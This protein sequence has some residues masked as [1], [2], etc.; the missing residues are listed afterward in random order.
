M[1]NKTA[2]NIPKTGTN[3][4]PFRITLFWKT[5][6]WTIVILT[7]S[8]LPGKTFEKVKL[9]D[10]SFMDLIVHF[11]MYAVLTFLIIRDQSD[12][13]SHHSAVKSWW[14]FPLI[15]SAALG[16]IT[17]IVQWLWIDGRNGNVVDFFLNMCGSATVIILYRKLRQ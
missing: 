15:V 10:I 17:E 14:M 8:F 2:E 12:K 9:F 3:I 1:K 7:L 4:L 5:I 6:V 13:T 16:L 11:F